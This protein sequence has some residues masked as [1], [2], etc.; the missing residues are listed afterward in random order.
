MSV[1]EARAYDGLIR[2][3]EAS[4]KRQEE[5]LA[6]TRAELALV[7]QSREDAVKAAAAPPKGLRAGG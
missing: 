6:A 7:R 3:L 2:R 5:T 4:E 1:I